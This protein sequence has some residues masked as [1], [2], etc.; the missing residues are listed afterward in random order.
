MGTRT[1]EKN[2][3]F[4]TSSP[5]VITSGWTSMPGVV[6]SINTN[7]MPCCLRSMREVRTRAN[8][9]FASV[10]WVVQILLPVQTRSPAASSDTAAICSDARSD[11]DSGSE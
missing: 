10:A 11:P 8:I 3:W 2:T 5:E 6:M 7:V 1:W 4:C 9:Q